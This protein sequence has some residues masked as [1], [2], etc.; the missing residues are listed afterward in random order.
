M[1]DFDPKALPPYYSPRISSELPDCSSPLTFDI[2]S[3]CSMRCQYCVPKGS[4]IT[5]AD[6]TIKVVEEVQV[7]D[8]LL[9]YNEKDKV[10]EA[11]VVLQTMTH[12]E[13][14]YATFTFDNNSSF[15]ATLNHPIFTKEKGWIDVRYVEKGMHVLKHNTF[16]KEA[17]NSKQIELI[18]HREPIEGAHKHRLYAVWNQMVQRCHYPTSPSFKYYGLRGIQVHENWRRNPFTFYSWAARNGYVDGLEID[19]K[20]ND[21]DYTP[22][23]CEWVT[24]KVNSNNRDS[25]GKPNKTGHIGVYA[26]KRT[27]GTRYYSRK[28]G[29]G[30]SYS[31][32]EQAAIMHDRKSKG[33]NFKRIPKAS[34]TWERIMYKRLHQKKVDVYNFEC[35]PNND[36]CTQTKK[37]TRKFELNQGVVVSNCFSHSQKDVNP[38]TKNAPLQAVNPDKFFKMIDGELNTIEGRL[39]YQHFF[40]DK[41]LLHLGG[42]ADSFCHYER[43]Y[44]YS[45]PILEGLLERGYPLMFSS[46]GPAITDDRYV[47]LFEK[48]AEKNTVTFQFSIV[49]ADD[50]LARKVEPGVPSPTERFEYMRTLSEMGYHCTLRLR[51]FII[52]V[53]DHTLPELLQ[54]AYESGAKAVSTEFYAMDQ[55]CVGSMKKATS[56]MGEMMG[57]TGKTNI[58]EYFKKLSPKERGGYNRLNRLVKEPYV[59]YIYEFCLAH[60]M[61]FTCSDPDFKELSQSG[62]CCFT[63]DTEVLVKKETSPYIRKSRLEDVYIAHKKHN[64]PIKAMS[65]GVW[66]EA[67]PIRVPY[68]AEW[69]EIELRNG[70][71]FKT[72]ENHINLTNK[73]NILSKDLRTGGFIQLVDTAMQEFPERGSYDT[74]WFLGMYVAE[75]CRAFED[76][77]K[78][79]L[80]IKKSDI[81][82]YERLRK[83]VS[84]LGGYFPQDKQNDKGTYW[85]M[86]CT[87]AAICAL[88]KT[89]TEGKCAVDK[90]L[91]NTCFN[92][93][94]EFRQGLLDGWYNGD[95]GNSSSMQLI[96][97]MRD[98]AV[99]LGIP[100][101]IHSYERVNKVYNEAHGQVHTLTLVH[102][103]CTDSKTAG[104]S[105]RED[106]I[107]RRT[108]HEKEGK[109][110][111]QIVGIKKTINKRVQYAY[112]LEVPSAH[113]F[114][115]AN[116]LL[117]HNCGM[118]PAGQHP[119]AVLNNWSSDQMTAAVMNARIEYH[120]TGKQVQ[121]DFNDVYKRRDWIFDE[122]Q[123]SHQDIG[124]TKYP[125]AMRKQLTLRHLLQE[126][127]N[128]LRS[129]ANPQSYFHGKVMACGLDD[130]GL[131]LA[132]K[133]NVSDYEAR[134]VNEGVRL[135]LT[136]ENGKYVDADGI[137]YN[138]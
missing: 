18:F 120:R 4:G 68:K 47:Q 61:I 33:A 70:V 122:Q 89:F 75:G 25:S 60:D 63:A 8:V 39:F 134:W 90:S 43:K 54:K 107:H 85:E 124:C 121:L 64:A 51:P 22:D 65:N 119:T 76:N 19:R 50:D 109:Y 84:G 56:K 58:F 34:F 79:N 69:Y 36:Y 10:P 128:N 48:Y 95:C 59:R 112:C 7:G 38:G 135:D 13:N 129:Y 96:E 88:I 82:A 115:L 126:K 81:S 23:N 110:F 28:N 138:K 127:W 87:S 21:G 14:V 67:K 3:R 130:S 106:K 136:Y 12:V 62:N 72:T 11:T 52:G 83:F 15:S 114:Q 99:S 17:I 53:T 35:W 29:K 80:T 103:W 45:Y 132:Y 113:T 94:N 97:D 37:N 86:Q 116:G 131:N 123:L 133:Y 118:P 66:Y 46:K 42:L 92:T 98:V 57:L 137:V 73:G 91:R 105:F 9:G 5:M 100:T 44:G 104:T 125:Y 41:F 31:L 32:P 24:H 40:K 77:I 30:R 108:V 6:G 26:L 117:T 20:N 74:G 101:H 27:K 111:A 16:A 102:T 1:T 2:Y 71:V 49:T 93:S 55:R 78:F